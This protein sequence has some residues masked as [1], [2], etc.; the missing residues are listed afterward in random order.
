MHLTKYQIFPKFL[1]CTICYSN[2]RLKIELS[3]GSKGHYD[4]ILGTLGKSLKNDR[5][6]EVHNDDAEIVAKSIINFVLEVEAIKK[7]Y[8]GSVGVVLGFGVGN[9]FDFFDAIDLE[10]KVV[11]SPRI[12]LGMDKSEIEMAVG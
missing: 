5:I 12:F 1:R 8:N 4:T 11:N 9:F 2:N 3:E 6:T 10:T 7:E